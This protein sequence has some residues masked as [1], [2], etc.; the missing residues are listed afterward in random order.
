MKLNYLSN[1]FDELVKQT[2]PKMCIMN[3]PL[4][5]KV[6][7]INY[8]ENDDYFKQIIR[9]KDDELVRLLI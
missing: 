9:R 8:I 7:F 5:Q 3:Y 1:K 6:T 4:Q 2:K